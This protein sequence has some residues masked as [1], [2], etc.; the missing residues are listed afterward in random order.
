VTFTY[1]TPKRLITWTLA[2]SSHRPT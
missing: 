1:R 2:T